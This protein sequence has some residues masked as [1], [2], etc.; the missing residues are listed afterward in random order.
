MSELSQFFLQVLRSMDAPR[1]L[2]MRADS[3]E[4]DLFSSSFEQHTF[5][6]KK[7]I[8]EI[9]AR[10]FLSQ[11]HHTTDA[12][13]AWQQVVR[14]FHRD[15]YG[16]DRHL[17]LKSEQTQSPTQLLSSRRSSQIFRFFWPA[18]Q[19]LVLMKVVILYFGVQAANQAEETP[20]W[21]LGA[22]VLFSLGNLVYFAW[23]N[24][25]NEGPP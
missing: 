1:E 17:H 4:S 22:A 8:L 9:A 13:R 7:R 2:E 18:F 15:H 24:R 10:N 23:K 14:D 19:T 3:M 11:Y 16:I 20:Y 21:M 5:E 6:E 25:R 12:N